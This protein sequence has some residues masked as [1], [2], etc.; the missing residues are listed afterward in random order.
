M[1]F[2]VVHENRRY[3]RA[4]LMLSDRAG[5]TYRKARSNSDLISELVEVSKAHRLVLLLDGGRVAN[6]VE[7]AGA[8]QSVR[9]TLRAFLDGGAA[10]L[11]TIVQVVTTKLDLLASHAEKTVIASEL[12]AFRQRLSS[13]F[14][15]R[16]GGLSFW[17]I[18]ARDPLGG[19]LPAYGVDALFADWIVAR[20]AS[21][22]VPEMGP[23]LR[24]EFD[25]L[26][27]RTPME[28]R[29]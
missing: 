10:G 6:P 18:S 21:A 25:R 2:A 14:T 11:A 29:L 12:S 26:L 24:G 17:E 22:L 23:S 7:R 8:M 16:L 27:L 3:A 28:V 20:P 4:D 1:H 19:F 15:Q 9:Q 13:D 5:E